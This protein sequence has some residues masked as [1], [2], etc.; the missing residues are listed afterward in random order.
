MP[1]RTNAHHTQFPA[2]PF[3]RTMSVTRFGVSLENVVATMDTPASHQGTDRPETKNS[4]VLFPARLPKKSAGKKQ[5]M[6]ERTTITQSI[7]WRCTGLL[8]LFFDPHC[9]EH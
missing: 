9:F 7:S 2:T 6:S 3:R 5:T 8:R 4:V 1:V